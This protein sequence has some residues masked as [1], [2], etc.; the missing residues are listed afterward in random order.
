MKKIKILAAIVLT[1]F[2]QIHAQDAN[3]ELNSP[4]KKMLDDLSELRVKVGASAVKYRQIGENF[5][6]ETTI[7]GKPGKTVVIEGKT[8]EM[9]RMRFRRLYTDV[10]SQNAPE[11]DFLLSLMKENDQNLALGAIF[12]E[13][14]E[15]DQNMF[16]SFLQ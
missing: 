12:T 8:K 13:S 9:G 11:K 5:H 10:V 7:E 3:L 4:I 2:C 1:S 16:T 6:V 15:K 14:R